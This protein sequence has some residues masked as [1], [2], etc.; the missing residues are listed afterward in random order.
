MADAS[1]PAETLPSQ[2][3]ARAQRV[4]EGGLGDAPP[5]LARDAAFGAGAGWPGADMPNVDVCAGEAPGA[6][7][8]NADT[9]FSDLGIDS[10]ASVPLALEIE[11]ASGVPVSAALRYDCPTVRLL[12]G[13][14]DQQRA[15][16][17]AHE[18]AGATA[19]ALPA[20]SASG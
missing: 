1:G 17:R 8:W 6:A 3:R 12:A 20:A 15:E 5:G 4:H 13:Y 16:Q 7:C 19:T 14:I 18:E 11:Q 10:L 2:L 9:P